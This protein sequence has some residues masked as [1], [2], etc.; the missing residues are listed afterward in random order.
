MAPV[1]RQYGACPAAVRRL[2]PLLCR[3]SD[4]CTTISFSKFLKQKRIP[5]RSS[6]RKKKIAELVILDRPRFDSLVKQ[7]LKE[8]WTDR[9]NRQILSDRCGTILTQSDYLEKKRLALAA[10][11]I[12]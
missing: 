10:G 9:I 8:E 12:L 5:E 3:T 4:Y 2:L 1:L 7:I 6:Y 11:K